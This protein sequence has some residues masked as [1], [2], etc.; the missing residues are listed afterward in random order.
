MPFVTVASPR[1]R[2]RTE[3]GGKPCSTSGDITTRC[4]CLS[5]LQVASYGN[6]TIDSKCAYLFS[7]GD[8]LLSAPDVLDLLQ[9]SKPLTLIES[10]DWACR[11][12]FP[13]TRVHAVWRNGWGAGA[14]TAHARFLP[15]GIEYSNVTQFVTAARVARDLPIANRSIAVAFA[16]SLFY[17]KVQW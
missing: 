13:D 12:A 17:R 7:E 5:L 11:V 14:T 6:A 10:G 16:G 15:L 9:Y 1:A 8:P 2:R 4:T 3:G